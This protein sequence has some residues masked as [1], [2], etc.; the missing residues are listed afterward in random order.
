LAL[1]DQGHGEDVSEPHTSTL[2]LL[3]TP[4][5]PDAYPATSALVA[6]Y[7]AELT[8]LDAHIAVLT[9]QRSR[10][11]ALQAFVSKA[12]GDLIEALTMPREGSV[13]RPERRGV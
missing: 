4:A 2:H 7:A 12:P 8:A 9:E 1:D 6:Q 13:P 10:L 5:R 11:H 3:P